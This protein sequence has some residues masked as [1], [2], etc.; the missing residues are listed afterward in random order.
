MSVLW[1]SVTGISLH[2]QSECGGP[3]PCYAGVI[4]S[5]GWV[6]PWCHIPEACQRQFAGLSD[7]VFYLTWNAWQPSAKIT[8]FSDSFQLGISNDRFYTSVGFTQ[9]KLIHDLG[10][11][12]AYY[13][14]LSLCWPPEWSTSCCLSVGACA[15]LESTAIQIWT[16]LSLK[17]RSTAFWEAEINLCYFSNCAYD[18]EIYDIILDRLIAHK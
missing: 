10:L 15:W 7:T 3:E 18:F 13:Q 17:F 9:C 2:S 6:P 16:H 12:E 1:R 4:R 5:G 14:S 11:P 8:C